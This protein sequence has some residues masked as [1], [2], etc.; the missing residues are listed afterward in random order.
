MVDKIL[1]IFVLIIHVLFSIDKNEW[2]VVS[3][4]NYLKLFDVKI[5]VIGNLIYKIN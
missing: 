3:K 2:L 5:F 1:D 4:S